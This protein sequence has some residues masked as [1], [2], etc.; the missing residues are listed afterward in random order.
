MKYLVEKYMKYLIENTVD[1]FI[2]EAEDER[3]MLIKLIKE[4]DDIFEDVLC[5]F[6]DNYSVVNLDKVKVI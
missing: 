5:L 2:T 1:T 6:K 4:N 3:E